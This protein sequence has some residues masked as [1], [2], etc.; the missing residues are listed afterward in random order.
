MLFSFLITIGHR[1]SRAV[2]YG[3]FFSSFL[4]GRLYRASNLPRL[5]I[6]LAPMPPTT[7]G[8]LRQQALL[9]LPLDDNMLVHVLAALNVHHGT[10][11]LD[12]A[13]GVCRSW[14][15]RVLDSAHLEDD[16]DSMIGEL[17]SGDKPY[18]FDRPHDAIFLPNGHVCVADCDNF[19]MQIV[20]RDGY[21]VGEVR[22]DGGTSCPTGLA[23]SG[24]WL[25]VVE[26]GAHRLSKLRR[27]CTSAVETTSRAK[28]WACVGSW[29]GGDAELRHPWGV[30]VANKRVYVTDQGNDRICVFSV[31]KLGF[32]FSFGGR[33]GGMGQLREP[34]CAPWES[35]SGLP[36]AAIADSRALSLSRCDPYRSLRCPLMRTCS[37]AH[38]GA[39]SPFV[40]AGVSQLMVKSFSLRTPETTASWSTRS[41]RPRTARCSRSAA[42]AAARARRAGASA[43]LR[44][45]ASPTGG[46]T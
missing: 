15:D 13:S 4:P 5:T 43:C 41:R 9:D 27:S 32:L 37:F 17:R 16:P 31:D 35:E 2:A 45:C 18:R 20:S 8:R 22:L 12:R 36:A 26:H 3:Y 38:D 23:A 42:T 11:A 10:E 34:R 28:R 46:S 44:A 21:Y 33:G 19:R 29:G 14:R 24:D 1:A 7:R 25:Y 39:R 30:A 6:L 40:H